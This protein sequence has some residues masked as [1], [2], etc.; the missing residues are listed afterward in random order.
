MCIFMG[1]LLGALIHHY[2]R[3]WHRAV[4]SV[5]IKINL[6]T[7]FWERMLCIFLRLM[8]LLATCLRLIKFRGIRAAFA[9]N[10]NKIREILYG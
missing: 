10:L 6:I 9:N 4:S 2:L 5:R 8:T 3:Q 1:I 7:P